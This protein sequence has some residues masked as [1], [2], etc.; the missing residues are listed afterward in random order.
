MSTKK[1]WD[2]RQNVLFRYSKEDEEKLQLRPQMSLQ[3][4]IDGTGTE[5]VFKTLQFRIH[6]GAKLLEYFEKGPATDELNES[7]EKISAMHR[8][9]ILS[10]VW[11]ITPED[12]DLLRVALNIVDTVQLNCTRKQ[13]LSAYKETYALLTAPPKIKQVYFD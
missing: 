13:M 1:T 7:V 4:F 5:E 2:T 11:A 9:M 6:V 3:Q 10:G 8:A 12:I